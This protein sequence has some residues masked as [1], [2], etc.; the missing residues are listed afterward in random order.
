M[1][2]TELVRKVTES[3]YLT[4]CWELLGWRLFPSTWLWVRRFFCLGFGGPKGTP[5]F[6]TGTLVFTLGTGK[7]S[8]PFGG[9]HWL[10]R[11]RFD[12]REAQPRFLAKLLDRSSC[13]EAIDG[14]SSPKSTRLAL[15]SDWTASS[16]LSLLR[17]RTSFFLR[18]E[19][20]Q[21]TEPNR[22]WLLNMFYDIL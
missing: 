21:F 19:N 8:F 1:D 16:I 2:K 4:Q 20:W 3:C 17:T 7:R 18:V 9:K 13:F 5:V 22:Q 11:R 10:G 6:C 14:K 15:G 12:G